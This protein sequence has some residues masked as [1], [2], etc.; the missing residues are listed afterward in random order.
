MRDSY[1]VPTAQ[2]M[3]TLSDGTAKAGSGC[4]ARSTYWSPCPLG[5]GPQAT[6]SR[7]ICRRGV[8][9]VRTMHMHSHGWQ[10][11]R[12]H[13]QAGQRGQ[14][15]S[16]GGQLSSVRN[17]RRGPLLEGAE[18]S[19]ALAGRRHGEEAQD[20]G[21]LP[22]CLCCGADDQQVVDR[23]GKD[24]RSRPHQL[25]RG[26][27]LLLLCIAHWHVVPGSAEDCKSGWKCTSCVPRS[28]VF[29]RSLV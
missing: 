28:R 2:V 15:Q 7:T 20:Q 5:P 12:W 29:V 16:E 13:V 3:M 10:A 25:H 9:D 8:A 17:S 18:R 11:W 22:A 21:R 19:G 1:R 24:P 27:C 6:P 4:S 26:D 23:L 14:I